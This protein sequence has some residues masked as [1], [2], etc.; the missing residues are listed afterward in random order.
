M[1]RVFT[2]GRQEKYTMENGSA[3]PKKAM[4][5]GKAKMAIPILA[6][7]RAVRLMALGCTLGLQAISTRGSG[8]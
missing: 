8:R 1:E 6:N 5:S 3:E 4:E 2:N 7:G